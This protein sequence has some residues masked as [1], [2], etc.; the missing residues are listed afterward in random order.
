[1]YDFQTKNATNNYVMAA[2]VLVSIPPL[3]VFFFANR[4]IMRGIVIPSLK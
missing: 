3:I 4:I 1:V 2:T